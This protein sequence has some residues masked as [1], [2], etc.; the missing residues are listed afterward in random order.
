[1]SDFASIGATRRVPGWGTGPPR[2]RV[3]WLMSCRALTL[4]QLRKL[5]RERE[6]SM[7]RLL[8]ELVKKEWE[9]SRGERP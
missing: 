2:R 4:R 6:T 1:M 9:A 8:A 5:A 3:R 7:S